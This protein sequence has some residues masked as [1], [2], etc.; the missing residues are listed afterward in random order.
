MKRLIGF[1]VVVGLALFLTA[2]GNGKT[3]KDQPE[4]QVT[5]EDITID[6]NEK[7]SN[8]EV[9]VNINDVDVTGAVYNMIYVQ[10]KM[11][12][13]R[14]EQ[15]INDLEAIKEF[16]LD[17]LI[18]QEILRQDAEK[19][20]I[21][22]SEDEV[23]AEYEDIK[24]KNKEQFETFLEKYH[25]TEDLFKNQ[26]LFAILHDKYVASEI[27]VDKVTTEEVEDIYEELKANNP[28]VPKFEDVEDQLKQELRAQKEQESLR[29]RLEKLK[30]KSTIEQYI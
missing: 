10:T 14:Y 12:M 2:C 30:E 27:S 8:D 1:I 24:V 4:E 29:E 28:D 16:T 7:V 22:V 26:L 6:E 25:L 23:N 11:E 13:Q 21:E 5:N 17:A 9:V 15:D 20:G 3:N 19:A 18:N